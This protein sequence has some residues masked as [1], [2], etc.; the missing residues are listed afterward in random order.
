LLHN[1][2]I[3]YIRLLRPKQ[4]TKNLLVFAAL[5]FV[6]GF[7]DTHKVVQALLAFAAMCLASSAVYIVNDFRDRDRDRFH[8]KKKWRPLAAGDVQPAVAIVLAAIALIAA[9]AIGAA[10]NTGSLAILGAYIILQALYNLGLKR[11]P[12]AD[13]FCIA[14]GFVLRAVLGA[15]AIS[16]AISGWLLFCTGALALLLGF[17][18]R[19]SEFLTLH[20]PSETREALAHYT[21]TALDALV[22]VSAC[23]AAMCYGIYC[24][25]SETAKKYPGLIL[26]S[27]FVFYGIARYLLIVFS[28]DE[29]SEPE[30]LLYKD[31]HILGSVI[32]YIATAALVIS[33]FKFSLIALQ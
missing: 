13:V 20:E 14:I 12:I 5:L 16:V 24:L 11:V 1:Q 23:A 21:R 2:L 15:A 28:E 6:G 26:T 22:I 9:I 18:K 10:I 4:W 32:L 30:T 7:S 31:L 29:G 8:P 19:R 33:G 17:S 25:E 27:I 3:A